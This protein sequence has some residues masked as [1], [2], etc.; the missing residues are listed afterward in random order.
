MPE[1]IIEV[2]GSISRIITTSDVE[3]AQGGGAP[4]MQN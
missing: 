1:T 3:V 4:V 2:D